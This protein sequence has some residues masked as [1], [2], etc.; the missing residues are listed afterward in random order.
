M[1]DVTASLFADSEARKTPSVSQLTRLSLIENRLRLIKEKLDLSNPILTLVIT[2]DKTLVQKETGDIR[3]A[4]ELI[5]Y[6][7]ETHMIH[8]SARPRQNAV[9]ICLTRRLNTATT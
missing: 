7:N 5:G 3:I 2:E 4:E 9:I 1:K 8:L 6:Y